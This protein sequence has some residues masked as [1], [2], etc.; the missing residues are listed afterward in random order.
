MAL[1]M[2][3]EE[4]SLR[5]IRKGHGGEREGASTLLFPAAVVAVKPRVLCC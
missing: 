5:R 2:S 1:A 4:Q 3:N